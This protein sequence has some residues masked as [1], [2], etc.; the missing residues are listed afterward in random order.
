MRMD[1]FVLSIVLGVGAA[2]CA[3][4]THPVLISSPSQTGSSISEIRIAPGMPTSSSEVSVTVCGWKPASNY[5]IYDTTLRI[6]GP[7][8]WLDLY[9]HA[10]G[11]G[12]Q[13]VM[14]YEHTES[15]GV[16]GMGMYTLH[17]TN[18]G[19]MAGSMTKTFLVGAAPDDFDPDP[20]E[21]F[22]LLEW[23][24]QH[25]SGEPD[26]PGFEI[27]HVPFSD[28]STI[29][30]GISDLRIKPAMPK[31][32]DDVCVTISGWRPSAELVVERTTLRVEGQDIYL[33]LYWHTQPLM[34]P[35]GGEG[36]HLGGMVQAQSWNMQPVPIVQY[37]ITPYSGMP[38]GYT[39]NLG[40]FSPGTYVLHV[41]NH[42]PMSGSASMS[43]VVLPS[44]GPVGQLPWW[45]SLLNA[46]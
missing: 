38:F 46:Q 26:L 30:E 15:L 24:T 4:V 33:D 34:P 10:P 14:Q 2:V 16:F 45:P 23:L 13:V 41:T 35:T 17:V 20:A 12:L 27:V 39:V 44:T 32:S 6:E 9:W 25:S 21:P 7:D 31:S 11:I 28:V 1:R 43:F 36:A 8:I 19:A 22:D 18:R 42:S 29:K 40:K 3:D 5:G 37:D